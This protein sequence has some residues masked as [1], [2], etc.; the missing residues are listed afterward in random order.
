M[1]GAVK[2]GPLRAEVIILKYVK[3]RSGF[4]YFQTLMIGAVEYG[5]LRTE[6][7]ILKHMKNRSGFEYF[8]TKT[9]SRAKFERNRLFEAKFTVPLYFRETAS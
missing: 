2:Y 3:N 5:P 6:V 8:Q 1:I 7:I 9:D 4:E